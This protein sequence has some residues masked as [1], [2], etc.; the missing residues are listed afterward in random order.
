MSTNTDAPD[1]LSRPPTP[2][3]IAANRRN[4]LKSTGPRTTAGKRRAALNSLTRGLFPEDLER[5]LRVRGE[6][7]N[8]FRRLHRDLIGI[9]E[10]R[11]PAGERVVAQMATTWWEKARR[12]RQWV[13]AGPPRTADLDARLEDLLL[14]MVTVIRSRHEHWAQR[15]AAIVGRPVGSRAQVRQQIEARLYVFGAR[16][17]DRKYPRRDAVEKGAIG[18]QLPP[19]L[20]AFVEQELNALL[21]GVKS[22]TQAN[23]ENEPERSQQG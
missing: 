16:K 3:R 10:P 13:A 6:D 14:L 11:D 20:A 5:Q 9:F 12:I 22:G 7:L 21:A 23:Q 17:R 1:H 15:L 8:E 19:D 18:D 4:A 2:Q